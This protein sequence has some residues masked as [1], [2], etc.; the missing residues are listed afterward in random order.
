MTRRVGTSKPIA[1]LVVTIWIGGSDA[2]R[3]CPVCFRLDDGPT[4]AGVRMAVAVL[5]GVT[6]TVLAGAGLF[7]VRAEPRKG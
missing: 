5:L 6:L 7:V 1:A 2:L 3:A 4:A